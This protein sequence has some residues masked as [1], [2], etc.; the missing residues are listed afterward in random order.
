VVRAD[1]FRL[2]PRCEVGGKHVLVLDDV[3][4]TGSEAQSAAFALR[5]AGA[6]AASV[7]VVGRWLNPRYRTLNPR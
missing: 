4:T 1:K 5:C 6:A 2:T 7:M 3:W